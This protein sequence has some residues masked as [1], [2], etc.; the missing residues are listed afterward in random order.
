LD[1][2]RQKPP[3]HP[4]FGKAVTPS[5][6]LLSLPKMK[7]CNKKAS[8]FAHHTGKTRREIW[9]QSTKICLSRITAIQ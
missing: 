9:Q 3:L 6:G 2:A 4:N 5:H 8:I 7:E 1:R